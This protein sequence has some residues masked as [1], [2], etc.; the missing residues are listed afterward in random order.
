MKFSILLNNNNSVTAN[1]Q[2][3]DT[4]INQEIEMKMIMNNGHIPHQGNKYN[5]KR[6]NSPLSAT[7]EYITAPTQK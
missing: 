7:S 3:L 4:K 1:L 6:N 2:S 5:K